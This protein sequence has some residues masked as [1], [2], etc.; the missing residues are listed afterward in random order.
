MALSILSDSPSSDILSEC[1]R[2]L[3]RF[4]LLL[5][6]RTNRT[7]SVNELRKVLF[8]P[9]GRSL[10]EIPPSADALFQH[11]KRAILQGGD[12]WDSHY[13]KLKHSLIQLNGV[14]TR[15]GWLIYQMDDDPGSIKHLQRTYTVWF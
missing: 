6:D 1:F 10:E 4:V 5:Y 12:C 15:R 8:S 13:V 3:D 2:P 14:E 7:S 11:A 9:K